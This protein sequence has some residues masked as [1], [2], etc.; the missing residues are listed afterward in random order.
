MEEAAMGVHGGLYIF[1]TCDDDIMG[2]V[3]VQFGYT[4]THPTTNEL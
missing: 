3:Y 2:Y 1:N 4:H